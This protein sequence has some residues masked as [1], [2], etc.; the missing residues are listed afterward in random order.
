ML[1]IIVC[2]TIAGSDRTLVFVESKR[3]ADFLAS[4]LS[5][6]GFPT[7]SIHGYVKNCERTM[8]MAKLEHD[9]RYKGT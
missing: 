1:N 5:Q 6:E 2:F 3:G 7:T 9:Y 4:L 8:S